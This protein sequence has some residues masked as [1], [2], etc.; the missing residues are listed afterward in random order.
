MGHAN[1]LSSSLCAGSKLL[2]PLDTKTSDRI[3]QRVGILHIK[4]CNNQV[5]E[6]KEDVKGRACSTHGVTENV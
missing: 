5:S 2:I 6:V 1:N 4:N 3:C